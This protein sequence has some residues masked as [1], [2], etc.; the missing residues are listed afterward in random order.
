MRMGANEELAKQ[1]EATGDYRVLRRLVPYPANLRPDGCARIGV[2]IDIETT[3]LDVARAE[4]IEL[5]MVKFAYSADDRVLGVVDVF[6]AFQ[7]PSQPIAPEI[8]ELTGITD[9]MVQGKIIDAEAVVR[10]VENT[11]VISFDRKI[12]ERFWP[13]FVHKPWACTATGVAWKEHGFSGAKLEHLLARYGLFYEAHR[14]TD[15]CDALVALLGQTLPRASATVLSVLLARARRKTIRIWALQSPFQLKDILK[16]RNY[17]WCDGADGRPKSWYLDIDEAE[18]EAEL[19]FP[20]DDIRQQPTGQRRRHELPPQ[21]DRI[22]VFVL[23][24]GLMRPHVISFG[25][26][27]LAELPARIVDQ[28]LNVGIINPAVAV[29]AA[30][31]LDLE[32][33]PSFAD[34][35]TDELQ[36]RLTPALSGRSA[37]LL[38]QRNQ[39]FF[40]L[41]E[42][43]AVLFGILSEVIAVF[44][45]RPLS[46]LSADGLEAD[47]I[48]ALIDEITVDHLSTVIRLGPVANPAIEIGLRQCEALNGSQ[49][50]DSKLG[51]QEPVEA[52]QQLRPHVRRTRLRG[53][54]NNPPARRG[55][56]VRTRRIQQ[57][58][59]THGRQ[60]LQCGGEPD[61]LTVVIQFNARDLENVCVV[62]QAALR[63]AFGAEHRQLQKRQRILLP[64]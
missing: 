53:R 61:L 41:A 30:C 51:L 22:N 63:G 18:L 47:E 48:G 6:Q 4:V 36:H 14:A 26:L 5:A 55:L 34:G 33:G 60:D 43:Q 58:R 8:V 40:R 2:A 59:D 35:A 11:Q 19:R 49:L 21:I 10:F 3:G 23:T 17:R 64:P 52:R 31:Q 28:L 1:L 24:R 50:S 25:W 44:A 38:E 29:R 37:A 16:K 62:A 13:I 42:L 20:F 39:L 9:A 7:Q 56:A 57:C 54:S 45:D 32:V 15:D 12:A 27:G 46:R